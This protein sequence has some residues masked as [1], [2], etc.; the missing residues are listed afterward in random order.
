MTTDAEGFATHEISN[1]G[2]TIAGA[3]EELERGLYPTG[4]SNGDRLRRIAVLAAV[5]AGFMVWNTFDRMEANRQRTELR[6]GID[7]LNMKL[8]RIQATIVSRGE[9]RK[10][11]RKSDATHKRLFQI[12][13]HSV[14]YRGMAEDFDQ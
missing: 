8:D 11:L 9:V 5:I 12:T 2:E 10:M 14:E 4:N 1:P 7:S 13:G 3:A 6:T